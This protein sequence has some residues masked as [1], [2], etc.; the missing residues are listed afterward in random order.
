MAMTLIK[1]TLSVLILGITSATYAATLIDLSQTSPQMLQQYAMPNKAFASQTTALKTIKSEADTKNTIHT[2]IK[3]MYTGIPVWGGDAVIHTP[4]THNKHL[5]ALLADKQSTING[6]FYSELE[7]DLQDRSMLNETQK[8]RALQKA[9]NEYRSNYKNIT[10]YRNESVEPLIFIANDSK[11][12]YAYKVTFYAL[13]KGTGSH[14]PIFILDA[15]TLNIYKTWDNIQTASTKEVESIGGNPILGKLFY[16]STPTHFEKLSMYV[17]GQQCYFE[18]DHV[19]L[20][21]GLFTDIQNNSYPLIISP[22]HEINGALKIDLH[23]KDSY[24]GA[25]SYNG[26][27]SPASDVLYGVKKT[28]ELFKAWYNLPVFKNA[29]GEEEKITVLIHKNGIENSII[30][31]TNAEFDNETKIFSIGDGNQS[32]YPFATLE[33]LA[34]ELAHGFTSQHSDLVYADQS[35]GMNESFSDMTSKA[36]EFMITGKNT[37]VEALGVNKDGTPLRYMDDPKKDGNSIDNIENYKGDNR[38]F[39]MNVH[40]TSGIFNKAFYHLAT[41]SGWDTK[42]AFDVM[43]EA[44]RFYWIPTSTFQQGACDVALAAKHLNYNVNDVKNAFA[45][46]GLTN[47][48]HCTKPFGDI[49]PIDKSPICPINQVYYDNEDALLRLDQVPCHFDNINEV[50]IPIRNE[51]TEILFTNYQNHEAMMS[52]DYTENCGKSENRIDDSF[53]M[54]AFS[55]KTIRVKTNCRIDKD[56]RFGVITTGLIMKENN[57]KYDVG[58]NYH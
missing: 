21:R 36:V 35:G 9:K 47:L 19:V 4:Q 33:I 54:P 10:I 57:F 20:K 43:V 7:K 49:F 56:Q 39:D 45:K 23:D 58:I 29:K 37:W 6:N 53:T 41:T 30:N 17:N 25:D 3:Q 1:L 22:C 52:I 32:T 55:T 24:E 11:A 16:D 27:Y 34:H 5:T 51:V 8:S 48:E 13:D 38:P 50:Y 44:N 28:Q 40:Y 18:N 14:Q 15:A 2:R 46:V 31:W 12:H 42:K 26:A